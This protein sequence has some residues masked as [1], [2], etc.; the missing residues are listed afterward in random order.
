MCI[1]DSG[2]I[3]MYLR[4]LPRQVIFKGNYHV[5][6]VFLPEYIWQAFLTKRGSLRQELYKINVA[7]GTIGLDENSVV[8]YY[9][10]V[11]NIDVIS[12]VKYL[13]K[14]TKIFSKCSVIFIA[15]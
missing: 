13:G 10:F 12:H 9:N 4:P 2:Q 15:S 5:S 11:K 3:Q 6:E 8:L 7:V 1:P 14:H